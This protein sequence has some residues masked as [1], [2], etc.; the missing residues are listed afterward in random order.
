MDEPI[1]WP[2]LRIR[3]PSIVLILFVRFISSNSAFMIDILLSASVFE[4]NRDITKPEF[5]DVLNIAPRSCPKKNS[6]VAILSQ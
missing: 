4:V 5:E 6:L 3:P 1:C 2:R